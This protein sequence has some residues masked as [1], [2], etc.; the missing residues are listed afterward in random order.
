MKKSV[1]KLSARC[2]TLEKMVDSVSFIYRDEETTDDQRKLMETVFGAA[3]F[4]LPHTAKYWTGKI[5]R[6]A[7]EALRENPG[8]RLTKEH[9]FPRKIAARE[10][11]SEVGRIR[12]GETSMKVLYEGKYARYNYVTPAENKKISIHQRE[13]VFT[14]IETAYR[15]AGIELVDISSE[16]LKNLRKK[17]A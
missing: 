1:C 8:T 11:F 13:G 2:A 6:A 15:S 16:E 12:N 3:I 7:L 10:L 5:S 4:Y 9:Q 14:D 17:A